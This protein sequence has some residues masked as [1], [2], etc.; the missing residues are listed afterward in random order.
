M[1]RGKLK[2]FIGLTLAALMAVQIPAISGPDG[3]A[4]VRA[5]QPETGTEAADDTETGVK[6]PL[7]LSDLSEEEEFSRWGTVEG[8]DYYHG[9]TANAVPEISYDAA[10]ERMQVYVDY[11]AN[12]SS[13]WSEA[14]VVYTPET[15]VDVSGYNEMSVTIW[16]PSELAGHLK[17]KFAASGVLEKDTAVDDTLA[18]DAGDGY[19]KAEATV[20]FSPADVPLE[21]LTLGIIGSSTDF[22]GNVYLDDLKVSERSAAEGFVEITSVPDENKA[23]VNVDPSVLPD[24]VQMTDPE[25]HDSAKALYSYLYMLKAQDK[26]LFG[27]QNDV[28]RSVSASAE[29]GDVEDVTGS[30]SGIF[31]LD[32]LALTGSEAGGTDPESAM[33]NSI[34]YSRR[35]AENGAIITLST[36]MPNFTNSKIIKNEDGTYNFF[37]CD[38]N[39]SKDLSNDSAKKILPGGE[40]NEVFRAYLDI[41]A[42]Y[43]LAM[44]DQNI[45]VIFRPFHENS[46]AWFWWGSMNSAETYKSLYRY[47]REYL[48][49]R[50]VHNMLYVYSPNGPFTTAEQFLS[51]YPGDE[52][53]DILSFDY[54]DDYNTY[55]AVSD[56][57]F[58][59]HLDGTC[60][61][62]SALAE[63]KGKIASISESGVRVMKQ[64]GSDNEGLLVQGNPVREEAAGTNWYQTVSDIAKNNDMP[65]FLVWANFSDTN[66]YVPYKYNDQYGHE[67]INEFIDYYNDSSSVFGSQTAFYDHIQMLAQTGT[68]TYQEPYGYMIA[69]FAMD[70]ITEPA[71]MLA[72]VTNAEEVTFVL[73]NSA[74]SAGVE[75][76][77]ELREDGFYGA[78]LT[79]ELLEEVGKTDVGV[80]ILMA[81]G[82]ELAVLENMSFGK[83]KDQ[84][85]LNVFEDFDYYSGSDGLLASA[86][87]GNS[88]A[89]CSSQ[90]TLNTEYKSNGE[91]G[92][93][94]HYVLSTSGSEVWTGQVK[95]SMGTNDFTA[96][97]AIE[98][99]VKPDG[100]GQKLVIQLN[101]NG[102][103]FEAYLTDFVKGTEARYVTIPFSSLKGKNGG[104]FDPANVTKFAVWCNS[105]VPEGHEGEWYVDSTIYLDGIRA[106][107][108][109]EEQAAGVDE[110]GLII[111]EEP[112]SAEQ[113]GTDEPGMD[114]PGTDEP[115]TDKPGSDQPGT[116]EPGDQNPG[117][118][119]PGDSGTNKPAGS[120]K[121]SGAVQTGD[122]Y[123]IY[124]WLAALCAA[125][126]GILALAAAR[127]R[128]R[129]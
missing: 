126:A 16:Y 93:A 11:S 10:N 41:I 6:A 111:T 15:A 113:P 31:G 81:D 57:S 34:M 88:A 12:A 8:W 100:N 98:L 64:D 75:V 49:S 78:W 36:H 68:E 99:W 20:Q 105:I 82:R 35:A 80:L 23:A 38:F 32:S 3:A 44:Q 110:N 95:S 77:A 25:A 21:S 54:Y 101:S 66:F 119:R 55:P 73:K 46:G 102:E 72:S 5:A 90:F 52:Y 103:D 18:E 124:G 28:S 7:I 79:E 53:V 24:A 37:S 106:V 92:G 125:G 86:Y 27:H 42:E 122:T 116:D 70:E 59:T 117:A 114:E 65:Y 71:E 30:V 115:G 48:E 69:P 56:G 22:R 14:K 83:H 107:T 67:M 13:T 120:S 109:T 45:P 91:Y 2:K 51:T 43:A 121:P 127:K 40:Y 50:G 63:E 84:A 85:P 60:R 108:I 62:L 89:G 129:N 9:G 112:L 76:T 74:E 29:L 87:T 47:L 97:N 26:V 58:F 61:A 39:E 123:E 17:L 128:R 94:F 118:G 104:T 33:A 96:Y 4:V 1:K 19:R